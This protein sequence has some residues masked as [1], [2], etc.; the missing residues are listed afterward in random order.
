MRFRGNQPLKPTHIVH[1]YFF[2]TDQNELI[3]KKILVLACV[4]LISISCE[5]EDTTLPIEPEAT[6]F[7]L[8]VG[9]SWEYRYFRRENPQSTIFNDM[10]VIDS[11]EIIGTEE[12]DGNTYY[13]FS[14][15]TFGNDADLPYLPDNG[16]Q[17]K[18]LRDSLGYLIDNNGRMH[19]SAEGDTSEHVMD[20]LTDYRTVFKLSDTSELLDTPVGDFNCHW[21]SF[22][23]RYN[24]TGER[25]VGESRYYRNSTIGEMLVT[26]SF[27]SQP[28]HFIEKRLVSYELQ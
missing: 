7:A 2:L 16:E 8:K 4:V 15:R 10:N 5:N 19:F 13:R 20:S 25:S 24:V 1:N 18:S 26:I 27:A 21:M 12:I 22:Y 11:V 17:F 6:T 28:T 9:N 14:T 23:Y 3:M